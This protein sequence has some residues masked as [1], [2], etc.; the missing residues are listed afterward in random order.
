MVYC[1]LD[2]KKCFDKWQESLETQ[3]HKAMLS[4]SNIFLS[5]SKSLKMSK[6]QYTMVKAIAYC[7]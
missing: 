3:K 4:V 5:V 2:T 7:F 1:V 6:A